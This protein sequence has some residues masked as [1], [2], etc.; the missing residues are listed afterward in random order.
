MTATPD[1]TPELSPEDPLHRLFAD[2]RTWVVSIA[3]ALVLDD[4]R[5]EDLAHDAF[6]A[7]LQ[8]P[9]AR[10]ESLRPWLRGVMRNLSRQTSRSEIRRRAREER[11]A[12]PDPQDVDPSETIERLEVRQRVIAALVALDEPLRTAVV[13]R[14]LEGRSI[15]EI[16]RR[17]EANEST[18]RSRVFRGLER[19]RADLDRR[20]G[21]DRDRWMIALL[22]AAAGVAAVPASPV[23][24]EVAEPAASGAVVGPATG[25]RS[26]PLAWTSALSLTVLI[27]LGVWFVVT[28]IESGPPAP[29]QH[30]ERLAGGGDLDFVPPSPEA[31][32]VE[33]PPDQT[34]VAFAEELRAI[35]VVDAAGE[36]VVGAE[37]SWWGEDLEARD[38]VA[39]RRWH[40]LPIRQGTL[41]WPKV[42]AFG[43]S[44]ITDDDGVAHLP[45]PSPDSGTRRVIAVSESGSAS[46]LWRDG[47]PAPILTLAPGPR[48]TVQERSGEAAPHAWV[49][50]E[51]TERRGKLAW[52]IA[53]HQGR[54]ELF[55]LVEDWGDEFDWRIGPGFPV[56][57]VEQIPLS[58]KSTMPVT[59][60]L[61]A[62]GQLTLRATDSMLETTPE[63]SH[64]VSFSLPEGSNTSAGAPLHRDQ[65]SL[66]FPLQAG[67]NVVIPR[68]GIDLGLTI[69]RG[70]GFPVEVPGPSESERLAI[71]V[72][73]DP[74]VV[75][76]DIPLVGDDGA[77]LVDR[78]WKSALISAEGQASPHRSG[79]TQDDGMVRIAILRAER[80]PRQL[81]I[82]L[83]PRGEPDD[84]SRLVTVAVPPV[85]SDLIVLCDPQPFIPA[86]I[87]LAGTVTDSRGLPVAH[88]PLE[89]DKLLSFG[90]IWPSF[91]RKL[92]GETDANGRFEIRGIP[93]EGRV[94]LTIDRSRDLIEPRAVEIG[95]HQLRL[96]LERT[97]PVT[98]TGRVIVPDHFSSWVLLCWNTPRAEEG[99]QR[100]LGSGGMNSDGTFR[101]SAKPGGG[102]LSVKVDRLSCWESVI[103]VAEGSLDVDCGVID[104]RAAISEQFVERRFK[105]LDRFDLALDSR[106][107]KL[108]AHGE[109]RW[110]ELAPVELSSSGEF[111]LFLSRAVTEVILHNR[112]GYARFDPR[113]THRCEILPAPKVNLEIEGGEDEQLAGG[114]RVGIELIDPW[115]KTIRRRHEGFEIPHSSAASFVLPVPGTYELEWQ[116]FN[117]SSWSGRELLKE[118][119]EVPAEIESWLTVPVRWK[120]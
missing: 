31:E 17:T 18:V 70:A 96:T 58:P 54:V 4:S 33:P 29:E 74:L 75:R 66:V 88:L 23:L 41:L 35:R 1:H 89:V 63:F 37:V 76:L 97:K 25:A 79:T 2:D 83:E 52:A 90:S 106:P 87:L 103:D 119:I 55:E 24:A 57:S 9:P 112:N 22:L 98:V 71:D 99:A 40:S 14:H 8:S 108:H 26:T 73:P 60:V 77:P 110:V 102:H 47:F 43:P 44:T 50:I 13:L 20:H 114:L 78:R 21:G 82:Y 11:V 91:A 16:A 105:V 36:P 3:R 6:V 30:R 85:G 27:G 84:L 109:G 61:P 115:R 62:H 81:V 5:A 120:E 111:S 64:H 7:A 118:R 101:F 51:D 32:A 67:R 116:Y 93:F 113:N 104:L 69:Y 117:G 49:E 100:E 12:R 10:R 39:W 38:P 95:D 86:P 15:P 68:V 56:W 80:N 48:V 53:D 65:T 28:G 42:R 94:Q 45:P 46:A 92:R 59:L 34:Q 72:A 107:W 19:L